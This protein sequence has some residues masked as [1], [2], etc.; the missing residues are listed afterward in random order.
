MSR[1]LLILQPETQA[2][3]SRRTMGQRTRRNGGKAHKNANKSEIGTFILKGKAE[4]TS[5][6]PTIKFVYI[7]AKIKLL[8]FLKV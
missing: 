5:K 1:L 2:S 4:Y 6:S 8:L 3:A 7:V